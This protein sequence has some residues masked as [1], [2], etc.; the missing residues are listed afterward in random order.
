MSEELDWWTSPTESESG[1][2][3][4]VTGRK[5][6]QKFRTSGKYKIR[7]EITWK[8]PGNAAG[9]PD[10]PT[11]TVME[12]V[13]EAME[14]SFK[15]DPVAVM[16]GIY[17]GDDERNWVFYTTSVHIFGKKINEALAPFDLL[18]ITIYTE[19]DPDWAEYD[20]MRAASEIN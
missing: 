19:N 16:T 10:E 7:V 11:A 2:L 5:D 6:V 4:M 3:I 13:Q 17:T 18:P 14:A 20:E 1:R 9:M 8:Y 12:S 15:K